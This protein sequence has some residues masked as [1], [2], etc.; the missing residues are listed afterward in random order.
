[1]PS[2]ARN[3]GRRAPHSA[4]FHARPRRSTGV[5]RFPQRGL[6]AVTE[7]ADGAPPMATSSR[8]KVAAII[9]EY[10]RRAHADVIV[11]KLLD[12]Y[13]L[14]GTVVKP[15]VDVVSMY[16]DQF[17]PGDLS[18]PFSVFFKVP[19]F[20]T[21]AEAL[22][23]GGSSL[24]VDGVVLVGEHGDYPEN[25][26]GQHLYPRRRFFE[27]CTDV[28]RQTGRSVPVFCDKHLSWN[29]ENARW[30]VDTARELGFPF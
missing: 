29:W 28:F 3:R 15:S 16:V 11:S 23:L 2:A 30:M 26:R 27:A 1:M 22:T 5:L 19:I 17:P 10:R 13:D 20:P 24:A 9:T 12:G 21:I 4:L 7:H 6:V 14:D 18:R 8:P 25:E